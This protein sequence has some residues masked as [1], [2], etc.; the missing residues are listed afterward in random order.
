M[1]VKKSAGKDILNIMPKPIT[2]EEFRVNL[3]QY[4]TCVR[5]HIVGK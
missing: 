5:V 3:S 4:I 2:Q 1:R